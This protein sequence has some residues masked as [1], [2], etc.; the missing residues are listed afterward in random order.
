[1]SHTLQ[2]NYTS[3]ISQQRVVEAKIN[4]VPR[5]SWREG[6]E[7]KNGKETDRG[8]VKAFFLTMSCHPRE[9]GRVRKFILSVSLKES[10]RDDGERDGCI[11]WLYSVILSWAAMSAMWT[12]SLLLSA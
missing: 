10:L 8:R 12:I 2:I 3:L 11:Q 6:R 5:W 9:S 1:M 7:N 4:N